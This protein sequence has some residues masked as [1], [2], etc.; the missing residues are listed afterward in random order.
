MAF[1]ADRGANGHR[2]E[3][4]VVIRYVHVVFQGKYGRLTMGVDVARTG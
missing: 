2:A 4:E 3:R 1:A